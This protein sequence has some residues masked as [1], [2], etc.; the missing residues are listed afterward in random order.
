[1][2]LAIVAVKT[3][4]HQVET[5]EALKAG[6]DKLGEDSATIFHSEYEASSNHANYDAICGWGWNRCGRFRQ[7]GWN[8]LVMERAYVADRY[9][10]VSL[11]WNGLNGRAVWPKA[12]SVER[13]RKNFN[14][15]MRPWKSDGKY[16]L[17]LGQVPTDTACRGVHLQS[18]LGNIRS[19][20]DNMGMDVRFRPHPQAPGLT[21]GPSVNTSGT[22]DEDLDGA[23]FAVTYNSNSSVDAVLH[24]VPTVTYDMGCTAWDVT[25]HDIKDQLI[26]PDRTKWAAQLAWKQWLPEEIADG[27]AW[28][29]VKT[30]SP[31]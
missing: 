19:A 10:W 31:V 4:L 13:W 2:R 8:V 27:T 29:A 18:W 17:L 30:V 21:I 1:M 7:S 12:E 28:K 25:S 26:K 15:L 3:M 9:H 22:L 23:S 16:A 20:M 6:I 14:S 5:A 24:G 11:G